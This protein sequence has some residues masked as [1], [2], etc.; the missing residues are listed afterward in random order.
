MTK[1]ADQPDQPAPSAPKST[2]KIE[3]ERQAYL[4]GT[5]D[6]I[7]NEDL[8][9]E[10]RGDIADPEEI[11]KAEAA[12]AKEAEDAKAVKDAEDAKAAKKD[13]DD[14]AVKEAKEAEDAK[15]I[16]DAEDVKAAKEAEGK[17]DDK[18]KDKEGAK[19]DATGKDGKGDDKKADKKAD[20]KKDDDAAKAADAEAAKKDAKPDARGIPKSRFDQVN[21]RRRVA[22][23]EIARRDAEIAAAKD[24]KDNK[25]D[26]EKAEDEYI[27]FMLDGKK[28]E[29]KAK[30]AEIRAAEKA[31]WKAEAI[32][33][34]TTTVAQQQSAAEVTDLTDQAM[35]LYPVFDNNHEDFSPEI[36]AKTMAFYHGYKATRPAGVRTDADA[37]VMAIAD[38]IQLYNLD[39]DEKKPDEKKL[40][41]KADIDKKLADAE[42]QGTPVLDGGEGGGDHGAS[43]PKIDD[44]TD[45]EIDALP[46]ATLAR[47]RGDIVEGE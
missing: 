20:D 22:E 27:E 23:E 3:E 11:A 30:R 26:F 33:E 28:P 29:A 18:N 40:P 21:E 46:A 16:K 15:A 6:D 9:G 17:K 4:G 7:D 47:M 44:L 12:K 42:Q 32:G 2:D 19:D 41:D 38:A 13:E 24:A 1:K 35:E 31:E 39:G 5:A 8:S 43:T 45:K 34:S 36:T 37:M 10:D 14:K 25:F